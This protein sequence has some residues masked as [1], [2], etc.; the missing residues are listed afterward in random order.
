[1]DVLDQAAERARQA[2]ATLSAANERGDSATIDTTLLLLS[3]QEEDVV[4][5]RYGLGRPRLETLRE[6]GEIMGLSRQRVSQIEHKAQRRLSWLVRAVGPVGSPAVA[7]YVIDMRERRAEAE[8]LR[9]TRVEQQE[10]TRARRRQ[11]KAEREEAARAKAR[12]KAWQ[13]KIQAAEVM[14]GQLNKEVAVLADR[15][16]RMGQRGWLARTILPYETVLSRLRGELRDL[17]E[18]VAAVDAAVA[19]LRDAPPA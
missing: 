10:A 2:L 14:R 4:R 6:I 3:A 12:T 7:R 19:G 15:I 16:G 8:R 5:Y 13:R 11:E 1:M 18:K 17:E 9:R